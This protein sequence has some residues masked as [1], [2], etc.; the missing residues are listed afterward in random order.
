MSK[1]FILYRSSAGS[2]KTYTLALNFI[3]LSLK[4]DK[5]GYVDYYRKILAI[6]F[7]NKASSEMKTR[8]LYYLYSLSKRK[9]VDG[10]L[11]WL[12]KDTGFD[13]DTIFL[14]SD[15]IHKNIIHNYADL[16]ISTIDKFTYKLIRTFAVDL[17]LSNNFDL[18]MENYKI[19]QPA[20]ALLL[21]KISS[22]GDK[23]S[24]TLVNF[25]FQKAE[26]G[27]STDIERDLE[28][29]SAQ[30]F[31]E[32][33]AKYMY[34]KNLSFESCVQIK[35]DLQ[36]VKKSLIQQLESLADKVII[37]FQ[38][39]KLN[40]KHFKRGTYYNY[41][42]NN[43]Y[44][45]ND[46]K[47]KPSKI[48]L[49]NIS[50]DEWYSNSLNE[51][52]KNLVDSLKHTLIHFIDDLMVILTEY[53][54][55][56]A[57][58]RNIY[59]FTVLNELMKEVKSYKLEN[60]IEQISEFNK[61]IHNVV[62]N[63]PSSFIYERL[64]ERYNH[65]LIDEFQDTSLLQWQNFL[66]LITDSLDSSKSLIVGDGK[67]SI[68][69]WRGGEVE[70]FSALPNIFKGDDLS[71]RFDWQN[72]L[73][74]Q[75]KAKSLEQNFRSRRNI[76]EFNNHFFESLKE[77]LPSRLES[78]YNGSQE[79]IA[80]NDGGYVHIELFGDSKNDFKKLILQKI[81]SEIHKI[82][83]YNNYAYKNITV[84]CNTR[85][86]VALVAE[87]LTENGVPVISSEGLLLAKSDKIN[88]LIAVLKY[89]QNQSDDIAKV[90]IAEYLWVHFLSNES[91][92]IIHS[93]II[94]ENGFCKLLARAKISLNISSLLHESLYNLVE[95][96]I[97]LFNF[98]DDIYLDFFLDLVL[99]YSEKNV[100]SISD[101]LN[102]WSERVNKEAIV[103]PDGIDAVQ[104]MTIHKSKGLAF[105]VVFIPFNWHDR[106]KKSEIWV[107]TSSLFTKKMPSALIE[108][109]SY[110]EFSHFR[111]EFNQEKELRLLDSLNKLYVAMTRPKDRLYVFSKYFPNNL[112]DY[113]KKENLNSFL[114]KYDDN[115]PIIIGDPKMKY[116]GNDESKNTFSIIKQK[117]L[118]WQEVISL[119]HSAEEIWSS[120]KAET[121][122]DWGKLLHF[123]LSKIKYSYQKDEV[124]DKMYGLGNFSN[125]DYLE[126]KKIISD[127]L[128]NS[129]IKPFFNDSWIV[130]NEKEIL[131]SNGRTYIPDRL[132]FSKVNDEVI[133]IDFK[134]GKEDKKHNLQITDYYNALLL[135]GHSN[136]KRILVYIS[137]KIKLVYL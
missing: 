123:V 42:T 58:L 53:Y 77:L 120:E 89:L 116:K 54:S 108:S 112:K 63:Q 11:D 88:T 135:M 1:N 27:K 92:H 14:R 51:N 67:Q 79:S 9:D 16:G 107:D 5:F 22:N 31:S 83:T 32:N 71:F 128:S 6:T 28:N 131:M 126:L 100:S 137:S 91:L 69:R 52:D 26:E 43:L 35:L 125:Q 24:N 25:A 124:I 19:I 132:L 57:I 133:I 46:S 65:Y 7:T 38:S 97:R 17:G 130:K 85:K 41:F 68:Y 66:P 4:G 93:E 84:L 20:V 117:K 134:T 115:Y 48:L 23:L 94:S 3:S 114:Y 59:S 34:K 30:L 15:L 60:N 104:I 96:I 40:K 80:T 44:S 75:Y 61:K 13:D 122:R 18:E 50:N 129:E 113:E 12:K 78:I 62:T 119:R 49:A 76:V 81:V 21:S 109:S 56:K 33:A 99:S 111:D 2:G 110:L 102:W 127:L 136:V 82:K 95:K 101:F 105:D 70:Q 64:G 103:M 118:N 29:F 87:Y 55:V 37:F 36:N 45:D 8:V 98:E 39:H 73:Q 106:N 47:W 121:K 72:K 86:N 74:Q 90:V 10:I